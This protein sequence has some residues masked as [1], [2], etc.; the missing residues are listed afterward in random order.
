MMHHVY[1][2]TFDSHSKVSVAHLC[3]DEYASIGFCHDLRV[4]RQSFYLEIS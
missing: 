2:M 1:R 3:I 4:E